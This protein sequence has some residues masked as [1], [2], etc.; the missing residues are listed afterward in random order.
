LVSHRS[1]ILLWALVLSFSLVSLAWAAEFSALVVNKIANHEMQG[2]IYIKGDRARL[3]SSTPL[4]SVISILRLDKKAMWMLM[5]GQKT[6]MEMPLDKEAYAKAL[7]IPTD[8]ASM[9]RLG[10]ETINGF[11]TDKYE[12]PVKTGGQEMKTT[13]WISKKLGVP[14][15]IESANKSFIQEYKDIKEGGVDDALFELPA[16]YKK[17]TMPAGLPKMK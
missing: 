9:K 14:L 12:T 11:D 10:T 13:M 5:A 4:G 7:N 6:Y 15:K 8:E 1:A 3:E 16:G 2:K 17:M